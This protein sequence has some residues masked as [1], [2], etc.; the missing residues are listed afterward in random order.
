MFSSYRQSFNRHHTKLSPC[1]LLTS[2]RN[3]FTSVWFSGGSRQCVSRITTRLV[4]LV[5]SCW[6]SV[7]TAQESPTTPESTQ[8]QTRLEKLSKRAEEVLGSPKDLVRLTK[9]GRVWIDKKHKR[10]VVDGI[11]VL[12][13]GQ[14]EMFACPLGTKEHES[15]VSVLAKAYHIHAGLLAVGAK[16]GKPTQFDPYQPA[17]GSTIRVTMLWIDSEGKKQT[18]RAQSWVRHAA[19]AR[20]MN[21]DWVFAGSGFVKDEESKR[22]LYLAEHGDLICV[23]N[24]STATLD[25]AVRSDDANSG[26][27]FI[28][29]TEK[30]PDLDTPVRMILQAVD[31]PPARDDDLQAKP[32]SDEELELWSIL[33][34]NEAPEES[35]PAKKP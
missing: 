15:I 18:A 9:D 4:L 8:E 16:Q 17:S 11:V 21:Y 25:L 20:E 22:D 3:A 24:F 2:P 32:L 33:S 29:N 1:P 19:A 28:A 14:L 23:A 5:A 34:D 35:N 12:K 13:N 27:V 31:S 30:I 26:L 6:L 10:I 7:A